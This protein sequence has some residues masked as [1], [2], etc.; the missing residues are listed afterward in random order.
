MLRRL[1]DRN[2]FPL[3]VVVSHDDLG[4][5]HA[6]HLDLN[7]YARRPDDLQIAVSA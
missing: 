5:D 3:V 7:L 1:I 6:V 2:L 4:L